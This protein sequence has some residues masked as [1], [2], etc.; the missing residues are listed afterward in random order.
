MTDKKQVA[1]HLLFFH[2]C[3]NDLASPNAYGQKS[4]AAA[5]IPRLIHSVS[6]YQLCVAAALPAL[7][8]DDLFFDP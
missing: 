4:L 7:G 2:M 8:H 1:A 5:H 3:G 6:C